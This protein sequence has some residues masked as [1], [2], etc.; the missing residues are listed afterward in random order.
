MQRSANNRCR[1]V[2]NCVRPAAVLSSTLRNWQKKRVS[3][4][5]S[6]MSNERIAA[7][8]LAP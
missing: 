2:G 4:A 6:T 1:S 8:E 5:A 7:D 3:A